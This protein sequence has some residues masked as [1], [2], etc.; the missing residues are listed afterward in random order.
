MLMSDI[1][2]KAFVEQLLSEL[3]PDDRLINGL[4]HDAAML[5]IPVGESERLLFKIDRAAQPIATRR[6]WVD[7]SM[8]GRLA[9]TSTCSD[10]LAAGGIPSAFMLAVILPGDFEAKE[11]R[12]LIFGAVQ[13]CAENGVIFA[14]GDTKEGPFAEVVGSGVGKANLGG[15][16]TRNGARP[17]DL[18]V[19]GGELG[20]YLGA[21]L[22]LLANEGDGLVS[23]H[24]W[25]HYVSHPRAQ[26]EAGVVIN[27]AGIA[28]AGMD[29]SDG[30]Y[31]AL[32]VLSGVHG[33]SID[34][35]SL[36]IH[37]FA[38]ECAQ[39]LGYHV[40]SLSLGVGDWNIVF[41]VPAERAAA[42]NVLL[43]STEAPLRIIGTVGSEGD[44]GVRVLEKDGRTRR[45][46]P[47]INE[48]FIS[49]QEDEGTFLDRFKLSPYLDDD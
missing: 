16:L 38:F 11:A 42:L 33:C 7:N 17:G 27:S 32:S 15:L 20:G 45:L 30:L 19:L 41:V 34:E 31:D 13:E 22:Q 43:K 46:R 39:K 12:R 47:V 37:P 3:R 6:G 10:I 9:V 35:A 29:C 40:L 1:G 36:P 28:K 49:R 26:W 2:E 5:D 4:G 25:L 23:S 21:Y 14:G 48:H 44:P 18:L 24:D 8:W